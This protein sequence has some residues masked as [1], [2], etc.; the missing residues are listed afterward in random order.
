MH[1][2]KGYGDR[3]VAEHTIALM[4]ACARG[5][6]RMDRAVRAGRWGP[7]EGMQLCGKTLGVIGLGGIGREVARIA[8]GIG[9][10]VIAWN[11]TPRPEAGV[12]L[13]DLDTLLARADVVSLNLTLN[14]ETRGIIDARA[15]RPHEAGRDPGQHRARRTGRRGGADRR[16]CAAAGSDAP[17]S[18]S[19]TPS[20]SRTTTRSPTWIM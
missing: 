4:F 10:E 3:A 15:H 17:G 5:L 16:R 14:D 6:A 1:T 8:R 11:R 20:R 2:I 9:M 13:V 12:P 7:L 18:M 19:S